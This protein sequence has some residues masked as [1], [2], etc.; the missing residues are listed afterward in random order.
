[1]K[2]DEIKGIVKNNLNIVNEVYL[3]RIVEVAKGNIRLAMLAGM[4]SVDEGFMA[5]RNAEDI[6]KIYYGTIMKR[7]ELGKSELLLMFLVSFLGPIRYKENDF[8]RQL[9]KQFELEDSE[10]NII[11]KLY[12]LEL[13]DWFKGEIIKIADQSFGN[14]VLYYVLFVKRWITIENI[15]EL[16]FPRFKNKIIYA[17]N[18]LVKLFMS[19]ELIEYVE[20]GV[21]KV[22]DNANEDDMIAYVEVFYRL[23]KE[24][25]LTYLKKYVDDMLE[26]SFDLYT[27]DFET[28]KN[29]YSIKNREIEILGGYKYTDYFEEAIEL[30]FMLYGKR[31]DLIMDIYF[32]ITK[33][34]MFD[35][36]SYDYKYKYEYIL[37]S[38]L[39][40]I[41]K[42]GEN[43]NNSILFMYIAMYALQCEFKFAEVGNRSSEIDFI[44]MPIV[45]CDEIKYLRN[46]IYKSLGVLY[47]REEYA[48][49][50]IKGID[51]INMNG[52]DEKSFADLIV[53][54]FKSIYSFLGAKDKLDFEEAKII[55]HYGKVA[56]QK[57][58]TF[59]EI[60]K[61]VDENYEYKVYDVLL[62]NYSIGK[63]IEE[64]EHA[65]KK[66]IELLISGYTVYDFKHMFL[67]LSHLEAKCLK[68]SW[69]LGTGLEIL[70]ELLKSSKEFFKETFV[71]YMKAGTPFGRHIRNI[72]PYMINQYGGK[73]TL[74]EI[75]RNLFLDQNWWLNRVW[76]DLPEDEITAEIAASYKKFLIKNFEN[77]R[78]IIPSV[79]YF[80]KYAKYESDLSIV[81]AGK[82]LSNSRNVRQFLGYAFRKQQISVLDKLFT[83]KLEVLINLY[84]DAIDKDF[85]FDRMLFW[86]IYKKDESVWEK[87][88]LWLKDNLTYDGAHE[89]RVFERMWNEDDYGKRIE[90]AIEV[91]VENV[92]MVSEINIST[93]FASS[94]KM[95]E[96]SEV[97]KHQWI[98]DYIE[99]YCD[100][101]DKIKMI[102]NIVATVFPAWECEVVL[103]FL[104]MN[105]SIEAFEKLYLFP[106]S[107]SWS[108]SEIPLINK[109]IK[110]LEE[111]HSS[112]KGIDYIE[113]KKYLKECIASEES[114]KEKVEMREYL[115]NIDYA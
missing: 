101:I 31:P 82:L 19:Q 14:Y 81:V 38:K 42:E 33:G 103:I 113:H 92:F 108:G 57:G 48:K 96:L 67:A 71:E 6:F 70:F 28:K 41:A 102:I 21:N 62:R 65:Q 87:Y 39:W 3:R 104:S 100:N 1:M 98:V 53:S 107:V 97:R 26:V 89:Q 10:E 110:F 109:K 20:K 91:L 111:L 35:K 51:E 56:K 112:L 52:L 114:Y 78:P 94:L 34:M 72:V 54:D 61:R 90:F 47:Q 60:D 46:F 12:S 45:V 74:A 83:G 43:Y 25:A 77:D 86:H 115:E 7:I 80:E 11:E 73:I 84:F 50:V 15:I 79:Y 29:L 75:Q 55:A 63:T 18:T 99:R 106:L 105:K 40:N 44:R 95:S 93:I 22:W 4:K 59:E 24:K 13:L 2:D 8:Y 64:V 16:G 27:F 49:Q 85:D 58:F 69:A 76:E 30:L 37:I 9:I 17:L 32:S 36:K 68:D 66:E 5:I 23:N 88:V